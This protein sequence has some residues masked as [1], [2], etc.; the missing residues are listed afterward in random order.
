MTMGQVCAFAADIAIETG[1]LSAETVDY[2]L[3]RQKLDSTGFLL[4][5]T[6][7]TLPDRVPSS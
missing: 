1:A 3:L 2:S 5:A 4:N 6:A 7:A